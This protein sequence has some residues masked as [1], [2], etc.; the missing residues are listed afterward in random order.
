MST[1]PCPFRRI[2]GLLV[3]FAAA[4]CGD[5]AGGPPPVYAPALKLMVF[6]DPHYFD[7]S[8][9]TTGAAFES[10]VA[11][12]RK[13]IAESD[14]IMRAM[15]GLVESEN[16]EVV[17]VSGD[18]TKDGE[19]VSHQSAA[20]Y[21][22]QM[23]SGGRRV[24]VVPGNHDIQNGDARSYAGD[25]ATAVATV[26][27]AEFAS[28]YGDMGY[29]DALARDPDSLSYVAALVPGL[30]LLALDSCIYGDAPGSS[31][32][33]GQFRDSTQA[34]IDARLAEAKRQGIR[35]IGMMHHGVIEHFAS[36]AMI[37]PEYLVADRDALGSLLSNGGVGVV[38][39]GH[40]HA[41]DIT[42][43]TP[44]GSTRSIYD[45]ETGSAV[46]YPCPYRV[47]D[48]ASDTL[49]L[50]TRHVTAIDYD[51]GGAQDLQTYAHDRLRLGLEELITTLIEA[52]PYSVPAEKAA[53]LSPWLGDGLLAHYAGD[54][55]MPADANTESQLL[56]SSP[57]T[58]EKLSG[59]MLRSIWTDLPPPDNDVTLD[60]SAR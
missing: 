7:P 36:Q 12:D 57:D 29:V 1:S 22:R 34:W 48:I 18:I 21:L 30:W 49:A 5:D 45:V 60:L 46:T 2:L 6:S 4:G 13:L 31:L 26:S 20:A 33:S 51:L 11:H 16:P 42:R 27:A 58:V 25:V 32:T 39:T 24:F 19:L 17:L 37:F 15:V 35:V 23:K 55:V 56:L 50:A 43:G 38:F 53:L 10:Y 59:T 54:E 40:F 9:G 3:L 44:K 14:A 28:I 47:V 41:N 8:L 52:P